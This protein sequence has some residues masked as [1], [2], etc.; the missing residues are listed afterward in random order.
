MTFTILTSTGVGI[1][2][3]FVVDN[4]DAGKGGNGTGE[5]D[6][7]TAGTDSVTVGDVVSG[8]LDVEDE[9]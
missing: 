4:V 3:L 7:I 1:S 2:V 6:A 5:V 9:V 8:G